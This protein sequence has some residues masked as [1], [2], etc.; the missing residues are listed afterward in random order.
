[1]N[2]RIENFT[3]MNEI[4]CEA[5]VMWKCGIS[6]PLPTSGKKLLTE[7]VLPSIQTARL[8]L[9]FR[10]GGHSNCKDH[11]PGTNKNLETVQNQTTML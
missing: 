5:P 1:M 6:N 7:V 4:F 2:T 10:L 3:A 9:P 8:R 11:L